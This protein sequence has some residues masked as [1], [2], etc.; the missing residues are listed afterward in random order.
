MQR[1]KRTVF[2]FAHM[3]KN[4]QLRS[5]VFCPIRSPTRMYSVPFPVTPSKLYPLTFG[6]PVLWSG[7]TVQE[8]GKPPQRPVRRL[9]WQLQQK[10]CESKQIWH[11]ATVT[12]QAAR[13]PLHPDLQTPTGLRQV[14][15]Q[16]KVWVKK[17]KHNDH[18]W[19]SRS[20]LFI[21]H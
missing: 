20:C 16:E 4:K 12:W 21:A 11:H 18:G 14:D 1:Q 10:A 15:F 19:G 13:D 7:K 2:S 8:K 17:A 5:F 3:M 6:S 9:L